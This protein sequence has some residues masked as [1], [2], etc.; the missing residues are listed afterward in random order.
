LDTVNETENY[1]SIVS[2][3]ISGYYKEAAEEINSDRQRRRK[4]KSIAMTGKTR[5]VGAKEG[6]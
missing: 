2:Y 4:N 3:S 1:H 6:Y 5:S